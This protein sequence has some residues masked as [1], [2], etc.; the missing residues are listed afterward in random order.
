RG[1]APGAPK[2]RRTE[3]HARV[4][5]PPRH[6][7]RCLLEHGAEPLLAFPKSILSVLSST[8][9]D[10]EALDVER[11]PLVVA[12]DKRLVV[13][14]DGSPITRGEPI[15]DGRARL[16]RGEQPRSLAEHPVSIGR[17]QALR[18]KPG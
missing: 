9:V 7:Y 16:A 5:R 8:H 4:E 2:K 3:H 6:A 14:P 1:L 12:H 18:E 15:L 10:L 11:R 13:Q 17:M